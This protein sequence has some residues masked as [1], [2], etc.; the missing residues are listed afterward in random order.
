MLEHLDNVEARQLLAEIRRV[1]TDGGILRIAVPDL[2]R[3]AR[4]YVDETKD[5]DAFVA[6]TFLTIEKPKGIIDKLKFL[7]VG[8]RHHHWMY[9][10]PSLIRLLESAGYADA[11]EVPAGTTMI[12]DPG[13]LDLYQ[14]HEE[15]IYVEA[16]RL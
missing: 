8:P 3:L 15:S 4:R 5:A 7:I 2:M 16:R 10:A 14:R 9:D 12:R 6:S 11:V 1:L 13:T